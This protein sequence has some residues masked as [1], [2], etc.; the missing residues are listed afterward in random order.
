[1]CGVCFAVAFAFS[2]QAAVLF[3]LATPTH[4][5]TTVEQ[6]DTAARNHHVELALLNVATDVRCHD[7]KNLAFKHLVVLCGFFATFAVAAFT[8]E[9]ECV[10]LAAGTA[11]C[12]WYCC[13]SVGEAIVHDFRNLAC[14]GHEA[15]A[16]ADASA[17]PVGTFLRALVGALLGIVAV[18]VFRPGAVGLA[19]V[20]VTARETLSAFSTIDVL[21]FDARFEVGC[22]R[23]NSLA[24]RRLRLLRLAACRC[25][26]RH[27]FAIFIVGIVIAVYFA[28]FIVGVFSAFGASLLIMI[29]NAFVRGAVVA[30]AVTLLLGFG[31]GGFW[32][33]LRRTALLVCDRR[34]ALRFLCR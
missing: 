32:L 5:G 15:T 18:G 25:G 11:V 3:T 16:A 1:M 2:E 12:C 9:L 22:R 8:G 19:A 4:A 13:E 6:A 33:L 28:R 17:T 34:T 14:A 30:L 23:C 21:E 20:P 7:N 24:R 31:R 26:A 29:S 10:A 27:V